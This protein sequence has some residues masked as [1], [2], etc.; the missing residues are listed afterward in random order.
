MLQLRVYVAKVVL[1]PGMADRNEACG[2]EDVQQNE[3]SDG[4]T[5]QLKT[6]RIAIRVRQKKQRSGGRA[7]KEMV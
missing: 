4:R 3:K 6:M 1:N 5:L 7:G 2:F